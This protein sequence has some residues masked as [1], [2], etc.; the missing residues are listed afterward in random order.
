M[1]CP[2]ARTITR[3][4]SRPQP[5][6]LL[7]SDSEQQALAS[8]NALL[9]DWGFD[10]LADLEQGL[11]V[12]QLELW[13]FLPPAFAA[14][15]GIAFF[16]R[17]VVCLT[18]VGLK[19]R[20]PGEQAIASLGEGL[21]L[22]AMT[23]VASQLVDRPT[24]AA[25]FGAWFAAVCPAPRVAHLF[26]ATASAAPRQST[27]TLIATAVDQWFQ[28]FDRSAPLSPYLDLSAV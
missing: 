10:A 27:A 13:P 17:F 22:L 14:A 21:A 25:D 5:P 12:D 20:L 16:R 9:L 15:Y 7:L 28:P 19:L 2:T 24:T 8:A 11:P 1:R 23:S 6:T 4:H 26:D 18:S 3:T